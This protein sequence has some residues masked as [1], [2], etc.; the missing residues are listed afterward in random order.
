M[1]GHYYASVQR[2]TVVTH[3]ARGNFTSCDKINL[4]VC[5]SSTLE[6]YELTPEGLAVGIR[7]LLREMGEGTRG[8]DG[9]L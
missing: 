1:F 9:A 7:E 4:L 3:T 2:P 8:V 5:K 6:V